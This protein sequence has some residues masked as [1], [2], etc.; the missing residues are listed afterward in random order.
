MNAFVS[1]TY[2][3]SMP[4]N[5][6]AREHLDAFGIKGSF[7]VN[8]GTSRFKKIN[9]QKFIDVGHEIGNHTFSHPMKSDLEEFSDV[10]M[11]N[12]IK[13]GVDEIQKLT[14]KPV[15]SFAYPGGITEYGP[16]GN[17][18]IPIVGRYHKY[19]RMAGGGTLFTPWEV[20]RVTEEP[21]LI[22]NVDYTIAGGLVKRAEEVKH[23][24]GWIV[25]SF[26]GI[27]EGNMSISSDEHKAFLD[28]LYAERNH[29]QV[30]TFSSTADKIKGNDL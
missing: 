11:E 13:F 8:P 29:I 7:F 10:Q 27:D 20:R 21:L 18:Y 15:L 25:F 4:S 28:Y 6:L 22:S 1:L 5:V 17:S 14:Q 3:D 19:A 2:D 30:D 16:D 23:R 24:G 12:E 9:W 26:H